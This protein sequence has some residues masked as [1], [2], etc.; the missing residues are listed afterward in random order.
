MSCLLGWGPARALG[1]WPARAWEELLKNLP[2]NGNS[3]GPGV[4]P[5]GSPNYGGKA[6]VLSVADCGNQVVLLGASSL[7]AWTSM[8]QSIPCA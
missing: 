1:S 2:H 8:H 3:L 4:S 7:V 6:A 5:G